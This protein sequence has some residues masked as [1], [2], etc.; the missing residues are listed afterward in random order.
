MY[1]LY[2]DSPVG[3]LEITANETAVTGL[4]FRT[5]RQQEKSDTHS[6]LVCAQCKKQLMEYFEGTRKY[7]DLKLEPAGTA[8]Q[9]QVWKTLCEVP[10]GETRCYEEI[11][12]MA[13]SPKACRAVGMANN[14]NPISIIVPCHRVIGKNGSMV[15]YGGGLEVKEAL[16]KLEKTYK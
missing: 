8:F 15:G 10:Y 14:R 1:H 11:A 16:L 2:M 9:K 7:F 12:V 4:Y 3:L 13:G 6:N 5:K